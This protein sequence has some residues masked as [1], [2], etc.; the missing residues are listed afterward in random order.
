MRIHVQSF[1]G[2]HIIL[3]SFDAIWTFVDWR[4]P[5][6]NLF[7]TDLERIRPYLSRKS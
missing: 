6:S 3:I 4:V 2:D 1:L 5:F 7:S